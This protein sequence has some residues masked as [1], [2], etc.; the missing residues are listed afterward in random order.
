M[1]VIT[2]EARIRELL[3]RS[4]V[5]ADLSPAEVTELNGAIQEMANQGLS[6]ETAIDIIR[7][8]REMA[9]ERVINGDPSAYHPLG[10]ITIR[11]K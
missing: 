1:N 2:S 3:D 6:P 10:L 5:V 9:T 4:G 7:T 8:G 11:S